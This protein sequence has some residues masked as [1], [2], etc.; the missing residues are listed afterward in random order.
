VFAIE[1][2]F[3]GCMG[4]LDG[5]KLRALLR[6]GYLM[7]GYTWLRFIGMKR[8]GLVRENSN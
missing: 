8:T 1:H 2:V 7:V 5:G 6:C 4:E 3:V